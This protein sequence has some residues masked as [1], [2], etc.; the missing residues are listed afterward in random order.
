MLM[1]VLELKKNY[2]IRS[3]QF[4]DGEEYL[5]PIYGRVIRIDPE[6][7]CG[8]SFDPTREGALFVIE[9][10]LAGKG[11]EGTFSRALA[12]YLF[13]ARRLNTPDIYTPAGELI[14]FCQWEDGQPFERVEVAGKMQSS[15]K[16]VSYNSF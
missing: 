4:V 13:F 12:Y 7:N 6:L 11:G 3:A 8:N 16:A 9:E 14:M 5:Y 1:R 10:I 15:R 2:V